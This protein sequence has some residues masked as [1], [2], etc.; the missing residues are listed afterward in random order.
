MKA[1]LVGALL[2]LPLLSGCIEVEPP[3]ETGDDPPAGNAGPRLGVDSVT[4]SAPLIIDSLRAGGEPVIAVTDKGTILIAAH[5]GYTHF[6]PTPGPELL[7]P[8]QAQSYLWRS[9]DGGKTFRHVTLL[10]TSE[11]PNTGPRGVGQGVSD[12]D[13]TIDARGRIWLT[14]LEALA[15]ASVSWSDDDGQTWILGNN[16]ASHGA[17]DRQWLASH[18]ST[19]YFTGNYFVGRPV[20]AT[21]DGLVFENRGSLPGN[22]GGDLVA[23]PGTGTLYAGCGGAVAVST[24]GARTWER[25]TAPIIGPWAIDQEPALDMSGRVYLSGLADGILTLAHSADEGRNW[26][27]IN[28]GAFFPELAN[29]TVLWPWTSAGSSGRAAVTFFG[30]PTATSARDTR[31]EWFVYTALVL[32]ADTDGPLVYPV[33]LTPT[34]HHKGAICTGTVCQATTAV[35]PASDRRMGDFF[36]TTIDKEGFLHVAYSNTQAHPD[37]AVSHV[38]YVR[39][40]DGPRLVDG[41]VGQGWP[42]QG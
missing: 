31:A 17:I 12:P 42:T 8:T 15:S 9:T 14:D 29:G 2:A 23:H 41:D 37:H 20:W 30:S 28:L 6:H 25:R 35:D 18:G 24:N 32:G 38:A 40:L 27:T 21:T 1:L 13:L 22:C 16:H 39:L 5:P 7:L 10:P 33:K 34:P 4:F 19:L 11:L 26:D 36:E 3:A